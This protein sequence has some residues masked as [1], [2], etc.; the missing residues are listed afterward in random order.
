MRRKYLSISLGLLIFMSAS[1]SLC[2]ISGMAAPMLMGCSHPGTSVC[3]MNGED[4]CL[5]E[6]GKARFKTSRESYSNRI[7]LQRSDS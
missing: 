3:S 2:L 4:C 5:T 1:F 7:A 6:P